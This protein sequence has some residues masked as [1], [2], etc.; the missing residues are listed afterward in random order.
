MHKSKLKQ[1]FFLSFLVVTFITKNIFAADKLDQSFSLDG[2]LFSNP[3]G[4]A[5]LLDANVLM[6]VQIL[7]S[8]KD[9]VLYDEQ[10][11]V[12]TVA[13]SGFFNIQVGSLPGNLK[14][15]PG[16]DSGNSM[17]IVFQNNSL[18]NGKKVTDGTACGYAPANGDTRYVRIIVK[19][20]AGTTDVL[21]PDMQLGS[22]PAALV[23]ET[24]QGSPKSDFLQVD[25]ANNLTQS[26]LVS[27]VTGTNFTTLQSLISS[28]G[29]GGAVTS[30]TSANSDIA[31]ATETTT[32]V[33]TLNTGISGGAGDANKIVK[34]DGTGKISAGMLPGSTVQN[35]TIFSGDLSGTVTSTSVDKIKGS[36]I[37]LSTPASGNFLKFDGTN[38]INGVLGLSDIPN[39]DAAHMP[40]FSGDVTTTTGSTVTTISNLS[41]S[42]IAAGTANQVLVN[43][44][45]GNVSS[46]AQLAVTRGGTGSSTFTANQ[47]VG[48]NG[49]GTALTSFTCS[50][51]QVI[52]FDAT[53]KAVCANVNSLASMYVNGGNSFGAAATLGTNDNN[54]LGFKTNNSTRMTI[55][56]SGNVGIGTTSPYTQLSNISTQVTD[57]RGFG[58]GPAGALLW[59]AAGTGAA[60]T[61]VSQAGNS[62]STALMAKT[63]NNS[64][65]NIAFE[66]G[67]GA[68]VAA[69]S[70]PL[71]NVMGD[72]KVGI[73]T[74]APSVALEVKGAILSQSVANAA[75]VVNIDFSKGNVQASANATNNQAFKL[76]GIKDG[77]SYTLVL[78]AQPIGSIPTF[79]VFSDAACTTAITNFD[80][81]GASMM[82]TS[83]STVFSFV[84]AASTVYAM[85]ATGFSK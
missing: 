66:V 45:G 7:S 53:G 54:T 4:T 69:A 33:L 85:M 80:S 75:G 11:Y 41:R 26:N 5:Y 35:S 71:F 68:T 39:I 21:Q 20:S 42:K 46:E 37:L 56:A 43:D 72:G 79:T 10:Q 24:L 18:I 44:A 19:D 58:Q 52:S 73:G 55:D 81:G 6:R 63:L 1:N 9:C 40:A 8:Q 74:A 29:S 2:E 83:I 32:P 62:N 38:W 14:R 34:L 36:P 22:M 84:R 57:S 51:N 15:T 65:A 60:G 28:G 31:V 50:L 78:T 30:V 59:Q 82:T 13:S 16:F 48:T 70:T 12:N 23:A 76:C 27:L 67:Y 17:S 47:I 61:F 25:S 49:T 64:A 77:G 3:A